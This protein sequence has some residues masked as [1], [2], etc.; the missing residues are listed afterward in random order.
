MKFFGLVVRLVTTILTSWP[1]HVFHY[2]KLCLLKPHYPTI[3][4]QKTT[5]IQL[6]NNYPF[7]ITTLMQLSPWKYGELTNK[8]P[9]QKIN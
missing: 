9:R 2:E 4:A 1:C 8:L 3:R 6:L 7:G 5:R